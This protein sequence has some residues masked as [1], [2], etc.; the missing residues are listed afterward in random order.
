MVFHLVFAVVPA[1]VLGPLAGGLDLGLHALVAVLVGD[2]LGTGQLDSVSFRRHAAHH[3]P[4][5]DHGEHEY[6]LAI[7]LGLRPYP[8]SLHF[9]STSIFLTTATA[10]SPTVSIFARSSFVNAAQ[11]LC[12]E[13]SPRGLSVS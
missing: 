4:N 6:Q 8:Y 7:L 12:I 9:D 10:I 1:S 3:Q 11:K 13:G 2:P 5:R